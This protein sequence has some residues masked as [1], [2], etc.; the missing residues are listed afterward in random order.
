MTASSAGLVLATGLA[1]HQHQPAARAAAVV[2]APAPAGSAAPLPRPSAGKP[3]AL[4]VGLN[5]PAIDVRT[6]LLRLGI[7]SQG[8]LQVPSSTS[9]AGWYTGSPRP[10]E[11]GSSIIAGHIDSN[12]GPGIF[13]RLRLLRPGNR[14]YVRQANGRLAVFRVS[15][16][17][18][19]AK[20]HFPTSK[21]YGPSPDAELRLITCGGTFD[22]AT[23]SYL[24]NVVVYTTEVR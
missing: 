1:G 6:K 22:Y 3:A 15:S 4:P 7:T 10:G 5:I 20:N 2:P 19:Y 21:V 16:V 12:L 13:F 8:T 11:I 18:L 23:R 17:H 9:V 14:V 24:S